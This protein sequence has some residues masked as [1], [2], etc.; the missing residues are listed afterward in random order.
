MVSGRLGHICAATGAALANPA[1]A[2][3]SS[4]TT[5]QSRKGR[6]RRNIADLPL[7]CS[8]VGGVRRLSL[9]SGI[10]FIGHGVLFFAFSP[11]S[12][13]R[14]PETTYIPLVPY[15]ALHPLIHAH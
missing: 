8:G 14:I 4:T 7:H 15:G 6:A 5:R 3:R 9:H 10:V 2:S 13:N 1:K 11:T 12:F